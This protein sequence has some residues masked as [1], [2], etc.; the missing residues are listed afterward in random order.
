[1]DQQTIKTLTKHVESIETDFPE[2]GIIVSNDISK[3]LMANKIALDMFGYTFE[4]LL[5]LRIADLMPPK[6]RQMH[7]KG[8]YKIVK[9]RKGTVIDSGE[10][11]PLSALTKAG[12]EFDIN[13]TL[14]SVA[15]EPDIYVVGRID[16]R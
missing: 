11:Y 13:L 16:I 8:M 12:V 5:N 14:S 10:T 9:T 3:N 7:N 2:A 1:M 4:E 15:I 6:Y